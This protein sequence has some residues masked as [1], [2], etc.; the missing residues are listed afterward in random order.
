MISCLVGGVRQYVP[1][2]KVSHA[3]VARD[4]GLL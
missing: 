2:Q 3:S 1:L 4:P